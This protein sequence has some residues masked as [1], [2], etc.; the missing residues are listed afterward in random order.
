MIPMSK[1]LDITSGPLGN[2]IAN[3]TRLVS[4]DGTGAPI[5]DEGNLLK[6]ADVSTI[7]VDIF[8]QQSPTP[9][10][11]VY[12]QALTISSVLS[13]TLT[14]DNVWLAKPLADAIGRNFLYKVPGSIF[15]A[16]NHTYDIRFTVVTT[17]GTPLVFYFE[18]TTEDN[19]PG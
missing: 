12:S 17:G 16:A 6:R 13:D 2:G 8:D 1:P 15:A 5:L 4:L 18:H 7:Q 10:V 11:P 3:Q 14:V 9:G 19:A